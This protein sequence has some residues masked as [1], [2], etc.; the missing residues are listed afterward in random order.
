MGTALYRNPRKEL[1][2]ESDH[3]IQNDRKCQEEDNEEDEHVALDEFAQAVEAIWQNPPQHLE[4]VQGWNRYH[5]ESSQSEIHKHDE[6]C[7]MAGRRS[8][9]AFTQ[10][11]DIHRE[12]ESDDKIGKRPRESDYHLS[13]SFYFQIIRIVRHRLRPAKDDAAQHI[14]E[15][16][17]DKRAKPFQ[18]LQRIQCQPPSIFGGGIA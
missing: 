15:E 13:I 18:M 4:A 9:Y 6:H 11:A 8:G 16:R 10:I 3:W 12:N 1:E 14:R 2:E 7:D 5:I 17:H